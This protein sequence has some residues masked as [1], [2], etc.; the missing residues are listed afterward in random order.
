MKNKNE[1]S[2]WQK[3]KAKYRLVILNSENFEERLSFKLS[4]IGVFLSVVFSTIIL[5]GGTA[6]VIALTPIREYIPGYTSSDIKRQVMALEF[7]SD[8]LLIELEQNKRYLGNIKNIV[9][10]MPVEKLE[11]DTSYKNKIKDEIVFSKNIEDSMLRDQI[12]SEEQFN[13]FNKPNQQNEQVQNLL[14]FKPVEGMVIEGF[15]SEKNHYGVDIVAKD[16]ATIKSTLDGVV[17]FSSWTS[18]TGN[19]IAIIHPNQLISV[20]KHNSI[21]LKK[22]GEKVRAG[23]YIAIIGNSGKWTSGPHL[24][25]ELWHKG[26]AINPQKYILF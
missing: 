22:E 3:W 26:E 12:E 7:L 13:V 5:V 24:H 25:F 16:N 15:N 11:V 20:Y 2:F 6:S 14:F 1:R 17:M 8:S 4:R 10:G 18:E 19:V 21:L 9:S 23:D